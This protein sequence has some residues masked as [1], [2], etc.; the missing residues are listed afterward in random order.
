MYFNIYAQT[1]E[2]AVQATQK[3]IEKTAKETE[4]LKNTME[5]LR[6]ESEEIIKKQNQIGNT[7]YEY[8]KDLYEENY[9]LIIKT[10][11]DIKKIN[12]QINEV[13]NL[14]N[15]AKSGAL[16][17]GINN[18]TSSEL[19]IS[20]SSLVVE[21]SKTIF[22]GDLKRNQ[23]SNFIGTIEKISQ[24]PL[25][26]G[27]IEANPIASL[28]KSILGEVVKYKEIKQE[29]IQKFI[30][31][32]KPYTDF[33][34]ELGRII[35]L[36]TEELNNHKKDLEKTKRMFNRYSNNIYSLINAQG[37]RALEKVKNDF[38]YGDRYKLS[39][40]EL[41]NI[42]KISWV[43]SC[44]KTINRTPEIE[45]DQS[46]FKDSFNKYI[47]NITNLLNQSKGNQNLKFDKVKIEKI[48]GE[49]DGLKLK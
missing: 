48:V 14:I 20:F 17:A 19:G 4:E 1:T 9:Q 38:K 26:A 47:G 25:I 35:S 30:N 21:N 6:K 42:N 15:V 33:Y 34:D 23:R 18:P 31:T 40:E 5:Q 49:L 16:I 39:L 29:R 8:Q 10:L 2:D 13:D 32:I 7:T 24:L 12:G 45:I 44:I 28:V 3:N 36:F 27:F 11:D 22:V 43:Q 37:I 46:E 41:K